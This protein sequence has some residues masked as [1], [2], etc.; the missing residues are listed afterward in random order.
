MRN[1]RPIFIVSSG[2]SGT[3]MMEKIFSSFPEIEIH[4]EYML[5]HLKPAIVKYQAG[6]IEEPQLLDLL[7][8]TH[9][10]SRYYSERPIW[11]DSSYLLSWIIA[12]LCKVFPGARFV[13]LVRDG[14][15]VV[16]S[17]FHKLADELYD[18]RSVEIIQAWLEAPNIVP[19]PPPEKKYWLHFPF[20]DPALYAR[21]KQEYEQFDWICQYWNDINQ[22]AI[23]ALSAIPK[24]QQHFV[25]LEELSV[26]PSS[27]EGLLNF[28]G[29]TGTKDTHKLLARPHNVGRPED[30]PLTPD[31]SRRFTA[32]AGGM[33]ERLGYAG[34]E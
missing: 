33:L 9:E 24:E 31:E 16:S 25:R 19:E 5:H 2:R 15:K 6:L 8:R 7:Q 27:L 1:T 34:K 14:R 3:Q 12:P 20:H 23:D 21:A 11:I 17:F 10:S 22:S 18:P 28:V 13:H 4:H 26:S 30:Y 29:V 32:I